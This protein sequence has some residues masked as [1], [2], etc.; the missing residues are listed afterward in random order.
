MCTP[1]HNKPPWSYFSWKPGPRCSEPFELYDLNEDNVA[2]EPQIPDELAEAKN[3]IENCGP[4]YLWDFTK[5]ITNPYELVYTCKKNNIPKS[6]ALQNPLSRSYFKM[7]EILKLTKFFETR[8]T[9][10]F[11]TSAHVCE[12]PGGFIE[13]IYDLAERNHVNVRSSHA[14]TLR[15]TESHIPGWRR[16]QQFLFK[17]RQVKIEYGADNTGNILVKENRQAFE[18]AIDKVTNNYGV[19]IF[20]ADGGFD[21]T[22]NY[23]AQEITVFPLLIASIRVGFSV[24]APNGLF[25]IKIFDF[26]ENS[27]ID[28]IL[29]MASHFNQW[30]IYKPATSRPCNSEQYFI[31]SGFRNRV[32][33]AEFDM[34]DKLIEFGKMPKLLIKN[35][36]IQ[37]ETMINTISSVI[38]YRDESMYNQINF[39]HQAYELASNWN[40][41]SPNSEQLYQ[42]WEFSQKHSIEFCKHFHIYY[43]NHGPVNTTCDLALPKIYHTNDDDSAVGSVGT[44]EVKTSLLDEF[45]QSSKPGVD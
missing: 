32:T 19:S 12:G 33:A 11:L 43:K 1:F 45:Q 20:T 41:S 39:L 26:F 42:L 25:I 5:K 4:Q 8:D 28:L 2:L 24:L 9:K 17:H 7:I 14:M 3:N 40:S 36:L 35:I 22:S 15:S 16:A 23:L 38:D 34:L 13:A 29:W 10:S 44:E 18:S 27:T 37:G 6:V 21:F 31:G 30:T